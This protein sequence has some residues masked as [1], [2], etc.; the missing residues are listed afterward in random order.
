MTQSAAGLALLG[1]SAL[2]ASGDLYWDV[3][4]ANFGG[5]NTPTAMGIW[6]VNSFWSSSADGDMATMPWTDG[7]NAIFSAGT[8]VT[9]AYTVTVSGIQAVNNLAIEEGQIILGG[10]ELNLGGQITT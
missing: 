2:P 8:N 10:G 9:G 3:N 1:L 4:G 5:S 7:E 6:G